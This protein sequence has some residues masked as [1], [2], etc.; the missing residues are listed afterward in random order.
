MVLN[1]QAA[2]A[3]VRSAQATMEDKKKKFEAQK[4]LF[5]KKVTAK[6]AYDRALAEFKAA[7]ETVNE[8]TAKLGVARKDLANT[9]LRAPVDGVI[10][11]READPANVV[12]AGK[13][14]FELQG[15]GE[16]QVRVSIPDRMVGLLKKGQRATITYPSFPQ[17]RHGGIVDEIG[18]RGEEANT[19]SST[20]RIVKPSR[21][22]R[23]GISAEVT[24]TLQVPGY[25]TAIALPVSAFLP[26][27]NGRQ[28][29]FVFVVAPDKLTL[30]KRAVKVVA[31]RGND[32]LI[33]E[34]L[35]D[36][37]RV[38]V[39]G[40]SFLHDGMTVKLYAAR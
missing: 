14:V 12:S 26:A 37:D 29:G 3:Q 11:K 25:K 15:D 28:K 7:Q 21:D 5:E 36:G 6:T 35:K 22:I 20:V 13:V 19:F 4:Q 34:G 1:V 27:G 33:G 32:V 23:A 31:I 24:F 2:E 17:L 16:L 9:I 38:V 30:A 40:V 8:A 39:A 10:S 18:P